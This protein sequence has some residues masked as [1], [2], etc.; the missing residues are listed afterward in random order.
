MSSRR[1]L[2]LDFPWATVGLLVV[3]GLVFLWQLWLWWAQGSPGWRAFIETWGFT[4]QHI[5]EGGLAFVALAASGVHDGLLTFVFNMLLL[6]VFGPA[7]EDLTGSLRFLLLCMAG[8]LLGGVLSVLI[9]PASTMPFVGAI[10]VV[11]T[12]LGAYIRLYPGRRWQPLVSALALSVV[13]RLIGWLLR[14]AWFV[15]LIPRSLWAQAAL[16]DAG[17][18]YTSPGIWF[19][20]G[21]LIAGLLLVS[22][23]LRQA[24]V[25]NQRRSLA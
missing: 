15:R 24:A 20:L 9:E 14:S 6:W 12:V 23:F 16:L 2:Y 5:G 17:F 13:P 22:F 18:G 25:F 4:S 21:G 19:Q 10:G 11:A 3:N 8:A 1:W 7:V